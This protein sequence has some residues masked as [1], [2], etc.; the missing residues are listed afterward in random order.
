MSTQAPPSHPLSEAITALQSGH[1]EQAR[2]LA[3]AHLGQ[4]PNDFDTLHLLAVVHLQEGDLDGAETYY[5]RA[6][7]ARPGAPHAL[8]GLGAIALARRDAPTAER[9][10]RK[11]LSQE[12]THPEAGHNLA[13]LLLDLGHGKDAEAL[14]NGLVAAHPDR[15]GLLAL[16][17]RARWTNGDP[18]GALED[19]RRALSLDP[20]LHRAWL[21]L[22]VAAFAAGELDEAEAAFARAAQAPDPETAAKAVFDQGHLAYR[23]GRYVQAAEYFAQ[24]AEHVPEG[25]FGL[26][27]TQLLMG[28]YAQGWRN[29]RARPSR[30]RP[31]PW[32]DP[33]PLPAQAPP[34]DL[35]LV[36]DE[37]IGDELFF[38]RFL[39]VLAARGHR[40]R[41]L[42]SARLAPLVQ[43]L[44]ERIP[45]LDVLPPGPLP[46]DPPEH[47]YLTGDLG[48]LTGAGVNT[49]F[50]PPL[51]LSPDPQRRDHWAERL[52]ALGPGP[53]IGLT[54]AAGEE[55]DAPGRLLDKTLPPEV[56]G[57]ALGA[58]LDGRPA[59]LVSLMR[60]P[61]PDGQARLQAL[62]G[63]PV[64]TLDSDD[65]TD[66]LAIVDCLDHYL[67]V[68]NTTLH[69]RAARNRPAHVL[70]PHPPEW[71]WGMASE[72]SPWFPAFTLHRADEAGGWEKAT[73]RLGERLR[74]DL[75]GP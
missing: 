63:R 56:L 54:W 23:R 60:R 46:A 11:V 31:G 30:S 6:L 58:A 40:L 15:P 16:R 45:G 38:L 41:Y 13:S 71:R 10:F 9:C 20:K 35:L 21:G 52:A 2:A 66:L 65:P 50:P 1:R 72:V 39:P 64:H 44:G 48:E 74:R 61:D 14:L 36:H 24:S 55:D 33:E 75:E 68:P 37:G 27:M 28:D 12:P 73:A 59:T 18:N 29:W 4:S 47:T 43:R 34:T 49:A 57:T 53:Y 22:G 67:A 69:L 62:A 26:A 7:E 42:P 32:R 19:Y 17:G 51:T 3:E 5:R 8:N 70:V 25:R